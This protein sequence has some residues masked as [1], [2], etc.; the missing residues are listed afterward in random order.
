MT[1]AE[2]ARRRRTVLGRGSVRKSFAAKIGVK[3]R[4]TGV[5]VKE[6]VAKDAN[7][8]DDIDAFWDDSS[9]ASSANE[10]I[11]SQLRA[12]TV[13]GSARRR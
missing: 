8:M 10:S 1:K 11:R 2:G 9:A 6:N 7:G 12:S 4:K 3:G 13:R 5:A